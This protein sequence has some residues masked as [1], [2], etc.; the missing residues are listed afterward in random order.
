MST[1]CQ[2]VWA[3]NEKK[4]RREKDRDREMTQKK[5]KGVMVRAQGEG[6]NREKKKRGLLSS[7]NKQSFNPPKR[8]EGKRKTEKGK[9]ADLSV[10]IQNRKR[11]N[12]QTL[13]FIFSSYSRIHQ[14]KST[15]SGIA[16]QLSRF[17]L[18]PLPFVY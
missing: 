18:L 4:K 7:I 10:C 1:G 15:S 9:R 12:R 14:P 5:K 6:E 2:R 11:E 17:Q 16:H 13:F 3:S 8:K